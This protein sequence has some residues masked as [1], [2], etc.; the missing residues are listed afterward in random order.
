MAKYRRYRKYTRRSYPKWAPNIQEFS[1]N[2]TI[3][4]AGTFFLESTL[5]QN[6][7]Q[8]TLGVSQTFTVKNIDINFLLEANTQ[9]QSQLIEDLTVYIMYKPQGM[10]VTPDYNIQHPEYIMNYKFFNA[11]NS[12]Q[13]VQPYLP[14][15]VR[16]R[17][18]RKLQ[19][20]DSIILF[21]KGLN[22]QADNSLY[23]HGLVKWYTKAN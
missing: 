22:Q 5:C 10:T 19:T 16:S 3:S 8:S 21:I 15:R 2:Q 12:D 20:G 14:I 13:I 17:L 7:T 23:I 6:P 9:N 11:P 4:T 1:S 18:S